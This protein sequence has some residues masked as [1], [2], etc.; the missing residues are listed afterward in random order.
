MTPREAQ[1]L[2]RRSLLDAPETLEG[3]ACDLGVSRERVSQIEASA[4]RKLRV[5][6]GRYG[7]DRSLLWSH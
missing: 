1:V 6:L 5:W 2:R 3:I 7:F 4:T